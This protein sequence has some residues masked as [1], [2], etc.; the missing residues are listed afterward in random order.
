MILDFGFIGVTGDLSLGVEEGYMIID[1]SS[2]AAMGVSDCT[3]TAAMVVA[4]SSNV[5]MKGTMSTDGAKNAGASGNVW[6]STSTLLHRANY[7]IL[8][9]QNVR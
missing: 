1:A 3:A 5:G 7:I 8:R 4:A 6:L 2:T 9:A